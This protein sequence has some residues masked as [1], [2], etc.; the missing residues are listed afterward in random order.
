VLVTIYEHS[1]QH[2]GAKRIAQRRAE[3]PSAVDTINTLEELGDTTGAE[4]LA[5]QAAAV[6]GQVNLWWHVADIRER[7][8]DAATHYQ[9]THFGLHPNGTLRE[10]AP[11]TP[12]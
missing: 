5:I 9:L 10:K 12:R 4:E 3:Q 8:G 2:E 6:H 7:R 1:G 11:A